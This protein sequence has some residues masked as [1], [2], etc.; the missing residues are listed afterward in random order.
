MVKL[1]L[2]GGVY[3]PQKLENLVLDFVPMGF[4]QGPRIAAPKDLEL[5]RGGTWNG[6]ATVNAPIVRVFNHS[7]S[8][9]FHIVFV[10]QTLSL[11]YGHPDI[12][13]DC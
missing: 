4:H 10:A 11:R 12:G 2:V 6:S 1:V 9:V 7:P 5:Q 13:Q 8:F 3:K